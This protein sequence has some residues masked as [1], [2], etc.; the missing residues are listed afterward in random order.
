MNK[1]RTDPIYKVGDQVMFYAPERDS[2]RRA[3]KGRKYL[4][5]WIG[6]CKIVKHA[7][8]SVTVRLWVPPGPGQ[9]NGAHANAHVQRIKPYIDRTNGRWVRSEDLSEREL[10]EEVKKQKHDQLMKELEAHQESLKELDYDGE[11]TTKEAMDFLDV[12]LNG[13]PG[14]M[15]EWPGAE[16]SPIPQVEV[17]DPNMD[18]RDHARLGTQGHLGNPRG[19][20]AQK[21]LEKTA[22][23][24][25]DRV[26]IR[27]PPKEE[28]RKPVARIP[29]AEDGP[30]RNTR[31]ATRRREAAQEH[32]NQ[33]SSAL[34]T[35][36]RVGMVQLH[37]LPSLLFL[38][39]INLV[40]KIYQEKMSRK[41]VEAVHWT[42]PMQGKLCEC[43]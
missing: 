36:P 6:P 31:R 39:N 42:N 43:Y 34:E 9:V 11:A 40:K 20:R 8:N 18:P 17:E 5:P 23:L 12:P 16:G 21:Y 29:E 28:Q 33:T 27:V 7:P 24:T 41:G 2:R 32:L 3:V 10:P 37:E 4:N 15:V 26:V 13:S 1:F 35:L 19:T 38:G 14:D 25:P 30:A 22:M